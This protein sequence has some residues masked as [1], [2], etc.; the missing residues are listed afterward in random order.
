MANGTVITEI[1][2][3]LSEGEAISP[4]VRDRLMLA[5]LSEIYDHLDKLKDTCKMVDNHD[6]CIKR[7]EERNK[8]NRATLVAVVFLFLSQI[9]QWIFR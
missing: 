1:K 4:K 6:G 3:I 7:L 9:V 8:E 2:A 5:A